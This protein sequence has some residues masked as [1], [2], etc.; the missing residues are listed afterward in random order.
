M[1]FELNFLVFNVYVKEIVREKKT[2]IVRY[3]RMK[4]IRYLL[5]ID[6]F[7][8]VPNFQLN[9]IEVIVFVKDV[10]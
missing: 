4:I 1:N 2:V 10:I 6:F 5:I 7:K 3:D 8:N 9:E